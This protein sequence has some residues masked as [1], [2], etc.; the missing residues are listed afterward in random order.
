MNTYTTACNSCGNAT[1]RKYAREHDGKCKQCTT[2]EAPKRKQG[3]WP[4]RNAQ[5]IDSGYDGYAREEGHY[6]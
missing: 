1:S 4:D 2:G 6:A 5:I 3:Y